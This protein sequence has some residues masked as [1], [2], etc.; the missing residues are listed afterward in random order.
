MEH[1]LQEPTKQTTE[2]NYSTSSV[3]ENPGGIRQVLKRSHRRSGRLSKKPENSSHST[4]SPSARIR[5]NGP[6][7]KAGK[8]GSGAPAVA[9]NRAMSPPFCQ[10]IP[11]MRGTENHLVQISSISAHRSERGDLQL[12]PGSRGYRPTF[13]NVPELNPPQKT[14]EATS[15]ERNHPGKT[16][17]CGTPAVS[18]IEIQ[19]GNTEVLQS[20]V[21]FNP[22]RKTAQY[23][24]I[25][26]PT[27]AT[28]HCYS[29]TQE[30]N[31]SENYQST[32]FQPLL[33]QIAPH[34]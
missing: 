33:T 23:Y 7:K 28:S 2:V 22:Q 30:G 17:L 34:R 10:L 13:Q 9:V 24:Q 11:L 25:F 29:A 5:R 20:R 21:R 1:S 19:P 31:N 32:T 4:D 18:Q 6:G 14:T 3:G 26:T 15:L 27:H 12:R 16:E 8:Q